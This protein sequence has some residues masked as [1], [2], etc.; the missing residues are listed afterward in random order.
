MV[1]HSDWEASRSCVEQTTTN[2]SASTDMLP[3]EEQTQAC[4]ILWSHLRTWLTCIT[5]QRQASGLHLPT[6]HGRIKGVCNPCS[7]WA[8]SAPPGS[9][10]LLHLSDNAGWLLFWK[11]MESAGQWAWTVPVSGA[12]VVAYQASGPEWGS[13]NVKVMI[14]YLTRKKHTWDLKSLLQAC[15]VFW[16]L[17]IH[18]SVQ[19]SHKLAALTVVKIKETTIT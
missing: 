2:P 16:T 7:G 18:C 15:P 14:F 5:K 13:A 12:S 6:Q 17:L 9:F 4:I 8:E 10:W 19:C 1:G 11:S 3:E